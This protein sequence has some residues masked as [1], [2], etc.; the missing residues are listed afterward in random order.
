MLLI[1]DGIG[2]AAGVHSHRRTLRVAAG[3]FTQSA[4]TDHRQLV[5]G[6]IDGASGEAEVP[7]HRG[8]ADRVGRRR[9]ANE[10]AQG[11]ADGV[12]E[13]SGIG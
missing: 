2:S 10:H 8:G 6:I 9:R 5:R 11:A 12:A 1:L 13:D 7:R 3:M 4:K